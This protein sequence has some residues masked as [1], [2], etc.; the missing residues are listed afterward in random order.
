MSDREEHTAVE[1][2]DE[3][4]RLLNA[5]RTQ[6]ITAPLPTWVLHRDPLEGNANWQM[7]RF[8]AHKGNEMVIGLAIMDV[9][10]RWDLKV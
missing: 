2:R 4:A 3:V 5:G 7:P 8:A 1:I 9:K 6:P 10:L